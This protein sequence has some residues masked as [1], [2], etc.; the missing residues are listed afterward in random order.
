MSGGNGGPGPEGTGRP[1]TRS[2]H[3]SWF[4]HHGRVF[5]YHDLYGYLL[6]MSPD[7]AA[8]VEFHAAPEGRT[9]LDV[10]AQF[11]G[12]LEPEALPDFLAILRHHGCLVEPVAD[13]REPLWDTYPV[14]ARWVAFHQP[15]EDQLTFWW[16]D[17]AGRSHSEQVAPWAALLWA[18][19]DGDH[20]LGDLL[21]QVRDDPSLREIEGVE[22]HVLGIVTGWVHHERQHLKLSALPVRLLGPEHAWPPYLRSTLPYPR[23]RPG[24]D[25]DPV[26]PLEPVGEPISPPHAY[27]EHEVEDADRQFAEVETTLS[28]LLRDPH[29]ALGGASYAAR[30]VDGLAARGLVGPRTRRILE[31]GG[32]TGHLAAGVLLRLRERFPGTEVRYT[33][34]DLSPALREAQRARLE[35]AGLLSYVQWIPCNVERDPPPE[36]EADLLLCNEVIGD[37]TTVKLTRE[38]LEEG[39]P[40]PAGALIRR[41]SL[42]LADAPDELFLN[43]GALRFVEWAAAALAPGGGAWVSEYGELYKY[44]VPSLQLDH[45][46]FSIHFGLLLHA[47]KQAG[48]DAD[49]VSVMELIGLD[50]DA[51]MLESTRTWFRSL[52]SLLGSFGVTLDKRAWT[53]DELRALLPADLPLAHLGDLRFRPANERC[54]GLAPHEF[55]ALLLRKPALQ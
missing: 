17:R 34:A 33:I 52:R 47:A 10:A 1:F 20:T 24:V 35:A 43:L 8:L 29:P 30:L 51:S 21:A 9:R 44:P 41:L 50:L 6:Q 46:E 18:R 5:L 31:V 23:W 39:V 3:V 13:E 19:A 53:E 4:A 38:L 26:D 28:H 16:T 14:R 49:F 22:A 2:R 7:V 32:G 37:L 12:K 45:I 36:G 27:Y 25:P 15:D 48:L 40:G 11:A 54:M 55:K 42:P